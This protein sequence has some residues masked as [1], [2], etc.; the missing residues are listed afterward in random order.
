MNELKNKYKKTFDKIDLTDEESSILKEEV[1][2]KYYKKQKTKKIIYSLLIIFS[3]IIIGTGITYADEIEE[4]ISKLIS[5]KFVDKKDG[6][7]GKIFIYTDS[8]KVLNY[9]AKLEEFQ[10]EISK[11]DSIPK[12]DNCKYY[13]YA[14]LEEKLN[15]KLLNSDFFKKQHFLIKGINYTNGKISN[16]IL[17]LINPIDNEKLGGYTN[18]TLRIYISTKYSKEKEIPIDKEKYNSEKTKK[19]YHINS[20]N[21]PVY[22]YNYNSYQLLSFEYDSILY[23]LDVYNTNIGNKNDVQTILDSLHY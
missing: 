13:S 10:C 5:I 8:K 2:K 9:D 20:L 19:L 21:V 16:I 12:D 22:G 6:S 11:A 18:I 14:E 1:I 4:Q 17:Y 23:A 15:I 7:A 3:I